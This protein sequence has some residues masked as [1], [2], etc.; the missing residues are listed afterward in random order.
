MGYNINSS[1]T[2]FEFTNGG[3]TIVNT[4]NRQRQGGEFQPQQQQQQQAN[5]QNYTTSMLSALEKY[6][7]GRDQQTSEVLKCPS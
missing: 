1:I 3:L 4:N 5:Q 2:Q 6:D 7:G